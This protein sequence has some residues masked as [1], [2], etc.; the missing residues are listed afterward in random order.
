VTAT[1]M[2]WV[3]P[4]CGVALAPWVTEHHC[5]ASISV[6]TGCWI[7]GVCSRVFMPGATHL[8]PGRFTCHT[9][10]TVAPVTT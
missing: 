7:C 3:C 1:P 2:G 5:S 6:A 10:T 8:C 9:T 4:A